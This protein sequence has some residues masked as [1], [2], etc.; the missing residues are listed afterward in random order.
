MLAEAAEIDFSFLL[1]YRSHDSVR[2]EVWQQGRQ[3]LP[4]TGWA[5]SNAARGQQSDSWFKSE[6]CFQ[7]IKIS[8][9]RPGNTNNGKGQSRLRDASNSLW[10]V[11]TFYQLIVYHM[12][13]P[14][15]TEL[16]WFNVEMVRNLR[17][18]QLYSEL[19]Y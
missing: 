8:T 6:V 4:K 12:T 1:K 3:Q 10:Q 18:N 19:G 13:K 2:L 17:Y 7:K 11:R 14:E 9:F 15:G 5:S 16:N